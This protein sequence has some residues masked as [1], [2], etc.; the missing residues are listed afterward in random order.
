VDGDTRKPLDERFE[1]R[2]LER[3][4][5]ILEGQYRDRLSTLAGKRLLALAAAY[6]LSAGFDAVEAASF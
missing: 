4:A 1:T 3:E 2:I 5:K 6:Y